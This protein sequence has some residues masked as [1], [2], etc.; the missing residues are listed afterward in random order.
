[1]PRIIQ[2]ITVLLLCL[3]AGCTK[4]GSDVSSSTSS[5]AAA[6]SPNAGSGDQSQPGVITA[7]EWDDLEHWD[8]WTSIIQKDTFKSIPA[9]WNIY[10]L[11]RISVHVI[12]T[13]SLPVI[14]I[15]V[16]LQKDG[17][18]IFSARTDNRGNAELWT[19]LFQENTNPDYSAFKI[20]INSGA[21]LLNHVKSWP[22]GINQVI[23][24]P[25]KV[26][27]NID[28][29]FVVDATGSMGDELEYL[30]TELLDVISRAQSGNRNATIL[31]SSV[32]YRDEGDDYL[33][34][35][36]DFTTDYNTTIDFIKDQHSDGGG[37]T[38][39]AVH[40]AL[41]KAMNSLQWSAHART[42]LLFLV[43][44]APPHHETSVISSI[45]A[46]MQTAAAKGIKIIPVTA[47]GIDKDTEFLMR[48]FSI[49]T[50][51]TYVFITDDSGIGESHLRATVGPY[52]VEYLNNLMVRLINKYAE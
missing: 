10:S 34:K 46:S 8:F 31:T 42:R 49:S 14:D 39:E 4:T 24:P 22:E 36:S 40:A 17:Q 12:G 32:F 15:A 44:D 27:N 43:L 51:G 18:T 21:K 7:G 6:V 9:Y 29:A 52:E 35:V 23:L 1:M 20:D 41:D 19:G 25:A 50:N 28:V 11:N 48:F 2:R 16:H 30:K 37:D 47:S 38:P 45:Q 26:E 13:D 33:T 5:L 3:L